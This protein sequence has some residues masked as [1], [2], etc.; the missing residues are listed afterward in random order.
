MKLSIGCDHGGLSLKEA[1]I[2]GLRER[3]FDLIDHGTHSTESVDYPDYAALVATDIT[4]Q[5]A[6]FGILICTSGVGVS[7]S[8]NK[9]KGV[10]AL[11]ALN[12]DATIYSRL[13]NDANII[14]FGQKYITSYMAL[15]LIDLFISTNFE[16]GRHERRVTKINKLEE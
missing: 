14:C 15:K 5:S 1:I 2:K 3:G 4:K 10:R 16:G 7:I 9:I 13:H 12:E 8:A 11:L 6:R